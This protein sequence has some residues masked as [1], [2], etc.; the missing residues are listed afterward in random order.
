MLKYPIYVTIDTNVFDAAKYDFS[1]GSSLS[2]LAKYVQ[3]GKIRVILS[4]I[5]IREAKKH[6]A[7]QAKK[8]C[9]TAKKLRTEALKQSSEYLIN[10]IGLSRLLEIVKDTK[11]IQDT[12][13]ALFDK[14]LI[15]VKPEILNTNLINLDAIINDYFDVKPPF[16]SGDKKKCE[17]PDAFIACQIRERFGENEIV[18]IISQDKGFKAACKYT[19]NHLF[20]DSLGQLYN[21][22]NQEESAYSDSIAIIKGLHS[23]ISSNILEHIKINEN[24][25]V[26]GLSY[27]KDGIAS[28]FDYDEY[29]LDEISN[30]SFVVHSI[31]EINDEATIATLI[32]NA[33]IS[34]DCYYKDYDNAL[35]DSETKEYIFVDTIQ[36]REE[37][38]ARFGCRIEFNRETKEFQLYPFR[39]ILGGD[40]RTN[41]YQLDTIQDIDDH[42]QE[43]RDMEREALG[44]T[45]LGSYESYLKE[46]LPDSILSKEIISQ[47][48]VLNDLYV[49]YE[50]FLTSYDSLLEELNEIDNA[51]VIIKLISKELTAI[52]DFPGVINED[53]IDE[54]EIEE[55]KGWVEFKY[56]NA[57]E[58][59][60]EHRLPDVLHYGDNIVIKGVDNS[61]L[62]F[63]I[64]EISI[65]PTEGSEEYIDI[66]L[67]NKTGKI[68]SGYVKLT[69]GYLDFDED[70]GVDT[71][72]ADSIEYSYYD[73]I[74]KINNYIISQRRIVKKEA[75]I[76]DIINSVLK[77]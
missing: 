75:K 52:S 73:I 30:L 44:F 47:F 4:D 10:Q 32:C 64:D 39:I 24:I 35:W 37:H 41:R 8:L 19:S 3:K 12:S 45:S 54:T 59:I 21:K 20:F 6:M 31:D 40:S 61:E 71:G 13:T 72:I 65:S 77:L 28:G 68:A 69:V 5:V 11:E 57:Y 76:V 43:I 70:G 26:C 14:F 25:E 38:H 2:L 60:E 50:D 17:F 58:I 56:D 53:N 36:M 1:E 46:S 7:E 34:V 15:D 16:E 33:N 63:T 9:G 48:D 49:A 74:E 27:D 66:Y 22:I 67:S 18:A 62:I 42:M 29:C 55:I 51:K 23:V